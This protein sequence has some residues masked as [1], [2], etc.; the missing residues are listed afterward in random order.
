M[1]NHSVFLSISAYPQWEG[2][3]VLKYDSEALDV[4]WWCM[5]TE[6]VCWLILTIK[7]SVRKTI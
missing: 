3:Y 7:V 1:L 5:G 6:A 4:L 2:I